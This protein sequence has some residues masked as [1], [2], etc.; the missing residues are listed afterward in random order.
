[1]EKLTPQQLQ[2]IDEAGRLAE[3]LRNDVGTI[4]SVA[5]H[6]VNA[7]CGHQIQKGERYWKKV[8]YVGSR[9]ETKTFCKECWAYNGRSQK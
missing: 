3:E 2:K 1:M 5:T 4:A 8:G 6:R 7:T 9:R